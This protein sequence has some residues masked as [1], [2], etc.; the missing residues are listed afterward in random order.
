MQ[1]PIS[2]QTPGTQNSF[3]PHGK[4]YASA[5]NIALMGV[6]LLAAVVYMAVIWGTTANTPQGD[7]YIQSIFT[8]VHYLEAPTFSE[9]LGNTWWTYFQNRA[10]FT[11]SVTLIHY[12]LL[13][14]LD[15]HIL[16]F[17]GNLTLCIMVGL[18]SCN[19]IQHR[20]PAYGIPV[21]SLMT[22]SF[23]AWTVSTWPMCTV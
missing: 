10:V 18:L 16:C 19:I 3:M 2:M 4:Q 15:L 1:T 12:F 13:G 22:L 6:A 5:G 8:V 17:I 11:K 23:Y 21:A 14:Y 20:L 9:K 7:G